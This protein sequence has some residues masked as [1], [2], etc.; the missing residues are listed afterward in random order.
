MSSQRISQGS[1]DW[2]TTPLY[3]S[4]GFVPAEWLNPWKSK[5]FSADALR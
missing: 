4:G 2:A 3:G 5:P 1:A